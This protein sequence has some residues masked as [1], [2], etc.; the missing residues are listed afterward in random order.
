MYKHIVV[1][2]F[3]HSSFS[4]IGGVFRYVRQSGGQVRKIAI[5]LQIVISPHTLKQFITEE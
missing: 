4:D 5:F 3:L 1:S 2:V